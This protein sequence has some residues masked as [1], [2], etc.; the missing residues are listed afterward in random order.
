M[1]LPGA[2]PTGA[3]ESPD[4][5]SGKQTWVLLNQFKL[6]TTEPSLQLNISY[7]S[8]LKSKIALLDVFYFHL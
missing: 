2:R 4:V 7:Y 1:Y 5:G 8:E 3:Y 6:L